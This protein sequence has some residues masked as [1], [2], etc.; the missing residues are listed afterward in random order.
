MYGYYNRLVYTN[1]T[2]AAFNNAMSGTAAGDHLYNSVG[3][4]MVTLTIYK[5]GV[6]FGSAALPVQVNTLIQ[7]PPMNT[8]YTGDLGPGPYSGIYYTV[9]WGD[10]S[11]V[12]DTVYTGGNFTLSHNYMEGGLYVANVSFWQ[13]TSPPAMNTTTD[14][15]ITS[16]YYPSIGCIQKGMDISI[17]GADIISNGVAIGSHDVSLGDNVV[18]SVD[19]PTNLPSSQPVQVVFNWGDNVTGAEVYPDANG[20]VNITASHV[21]NTSGVYTPS[22]QVLDQMTYQIGLATSDSLYLTVRAGSI[23]GPSSV[24]AASGTFTVNTSIPDTLGT[25]GTDWSASW[26][27]TDSSGTPVVGSSASNVNY[28]PQSGLLQANINYG[29]LTSGDQYSVML[30]ILD[31]N[32]NVISSEV[33][34]YVTAQ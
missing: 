30:D 28:D 9:D 13:E 7:Y 19:I 25:Y 1:S 27:L 22:I 12:N 20:W 21:Y 6:E 16:L 29:S 32:G 23:N 34:D 24:P 8:V 26:T 4:Y 14:N 17:N 11:T 5:N 15:K 10:N 3:D 31:G 2:G 33:Y 18:A